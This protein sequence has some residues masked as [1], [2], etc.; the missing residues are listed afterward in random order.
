MIT[1]RDF[2]WGKVTLEVS[3]KR[4][5]LKSVLSLMTSLMD[6]DVETGLPVQDSQT[7]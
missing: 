3:D 6:C 7:G 5:T 2:E 1:C 4:M